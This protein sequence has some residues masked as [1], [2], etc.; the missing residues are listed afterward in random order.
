MT[1]SHSRDDT[2]RTTIGG[3]STRKMIL[4]LSPEQGKERGKRKIEDDGSG[5][6]DRTYQPCYSKIDEGEQR[7]SRLSSELRRRRSAT[8]FPIALSG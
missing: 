2:C 7:R 8:P 3:C 1:A 5:G 4:I 6:G